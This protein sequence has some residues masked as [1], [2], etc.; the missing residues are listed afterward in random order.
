MAIA[1]HKTKRI[2]SA[3]LSAILIAPLL[4][5][6]FAPSAQ[7][8]SN[9]QLSR[10]IQAQ[11]IGRAGESIQL[12]VYS[13]LANGSTTST[14]VFY[15]W[16]Y[17]APNGVERP[18]DKIRET[19]SE[20]VNS[21]QHGKISIPIVT[22]GRYVVA[23]CATSPSA[24]LPPYNYFWDNSGLADGFAWEQVRTCTNIYVTVGQEPALIS[25]GERMIYAN[26]V[27]NTQ[28]SNPINIGLFDAAGNRTILKSGESLNVSMTTGQVS[29]TSAASGSA[30]NNQVS[31]T[32]ANSFSDGT[33]QAF[34]GNSEQANQ[35]I[36]IA[37]GGT[38]SALTAA[39]ISLDTRSRAAITGQTPNLLNFQ[40]GVFGTGS[41]GDFYRWGVLRAGFTD[42]VSGND[43]LNNT[44]LKPTR[45]K[46]SSGVRAKKM[47]NCWENWSSSCGAYGFLAEDGSI[48]AEGGTDG[49]FPVSQRISATLK[50]LILPFSPSLKVV[51]FSYG[52]RR[53]VLSD[54]S[55]WQRNDSFTYSKVDLSSV[56]TPIIK[57]VIYL[58]Q[59]QT[60]IML[61]D[62]GEIYSVGGNAQGQLGQGSDSA[63]TLG[64]V[65][66][67]TGR[68]ASR[69]FGGRT[70]AGAQL[71]TGA[72]VTWG[73]N[74]SGEQGKAPAE[75]PYLN[76]PRILVTPAEISVTRI[77]AMDGGV[78]AY[79]TNE[80]GRSTTY[81]ARSELGIRLASL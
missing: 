36:T 30:L 15:G 20:I 38:I 13:K 63:A 57:S 27:S 44:L 79:G 21:I 60:T 22:S 42:N 48:W 5:L 59:S 2:F 32:S 37:G 76:T 75:V 16:I 14:D 39:T 74:S 31:L 4:S 80:A 10:G 17:E 23:V 28:T 53:L 52:A 70:W 40:N 41:D 11:G 62:N 47:W 35:T 73:N 6:V 61:A 33:Y 71:T 24:P 56:S 64:K 34:V 50:P 7:A 68:S 65:V 8:V 58:W 19:S 55:V 72:I 45:F 9:L 77:D 12:D 26:P 78:L 43:V 25:V 81:L 18:V 1:R 51:D 3:A 67:P 29:T 69:I 66:L 54:G 46:I 49:N